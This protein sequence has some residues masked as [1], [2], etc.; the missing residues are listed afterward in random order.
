MELPKQFEPHEIEKRWSDHWLASQIFAWDP[1]GSRENTF[2]V[3]TPPPTVSGS[4]HMGHL[5][6]YSQ[7]DFIVRY[8]R[9]KGKNIFFPIGWDDNGLPTERRVQNLYNVRC[10]PHLHPNPGLKLERGR[11]GDPV[12]IS[13]KDFIALCH[14]VTQEDEEA[15]K[16]LWTRLGMSFDWSLEYATIDEHCRRTSQASFLELLEK[17]EIYQAVRP[18]MWDVD[19]RTA[20][21]QAEVADREV[22][23]AYHFLRFGIEGT[24]EYVVIATTRPE[25]LPA[26]VAVLAHP[27]DERYKKYIGKN[28]VTPLFHVPVPIMADAKA[29]PEKGTGIVM[30]CTYGD[31]TDVEWQRQYGLPV[32]QVLDRDGRLM[33]ITFVRRG[34]T[35]DAAFPSLNPDAANEA[36]QH[37]Q[38]KYVKQAQK[39]LIEYAVSLDGQGGMRPIID[40]PK[41]DVTHIVRFFEKG[42]R[43]L[44]WIP[45]R[46]WFCRI[47]EHRDELIEQGRK[48]NWIPKHMGIR[49]EHWVEGLNQDW[50][51]SRQRFF[52]VPVP[53]W[54][55]VDEHG[56]VMYDQ[57]L[58]PSRDQLPIDPLDDVPE[59]YTEDQ[60]DQPG[61]FTGDPDVLDTW[62]T[63]SLTPQIAS[64]W[65]DNLQR[66]ARLFPMDIRPQAHEIIRTWAFYTIVKAWLHERKIPWKNVLISGWVLDP[67]R[68]KMSKSQGNVVTPEPV[69]EQF[70]ADSV[71][72]W[73]ARARLGVDTAYDEQVFK[74]GKRLSTKL[75]NAAK[76]AVGRFMEL[77]AQSLTA[78]K[79]V[80]ETDRTIIAELRPLIERAT[81]A[82]EQF[83]YAQ[84]LQLT[85]DFF[86]QTFCDNYLELA[87][88]RTYDEG[89]T[90]GR[91]SAAATLRLVLRVL[92]RLFAPF[93][94]FLTEEVWHWAFSKDTDM[95][96]SVHRSPWPCLEEFA[97]VP[98]PV[99]PETYSLI[100]TI[101]DAVRKAKA[102][103]NLSM[104]APVTAVSLVVR[105]DLVDAVEKVREDIVRML[106]IGSWTIA[107]GEPG[108]TLV[109]V[110]TKLSE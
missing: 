97:Q 8:Q 72:Y 105:P 15:F 53:V 43:P 28:A 59:G 1:N 55:K 74:V 85:E 20:I 96:E 90:P 56:Q 41:Q 51:L 21:A 82:F 47:L 58:L 95:H 19:F 9:M 38:G 37:I 35:C 24:D 69:I 11:K 98:A 100:T 87:K 31:Q 13:R 49:Y 60:R 104:K 94:P 34:E 50:C 77:D 23:S 14:E 76:F 33:P 67:D 99:S 103:A 6:S 109:S 17:G 2:V 80:V 42:D 62:A 32:R 73:S 16:R 54:Y 44:E 10:E 45:A 68:K 88:A 101:L 65:V 30:V 93:M 89:I 86:W 106:H 108:G 70:S 40:R 71:R 52:G 75:F 18:V 22:A 102:E 48:V 81:Q 78:D 107:Q 3:D 29:D 63:S 27:D 26:C 64:G 84:A 25:L 12:P 92:V 46:Q 57:R 39:A 91:L 7:Q 83:D 79:I 61:G 36:Y 66:H 5:F 4:L 110:E